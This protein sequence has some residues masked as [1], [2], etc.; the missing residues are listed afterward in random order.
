MTEEL[1]SEEERVVEALTEHDS[2]RY[3]GIEAELFEEQN[4]DAKK[5]NDVKDMLE[6]LEQRGV[7]EKH[8]DGRYTR[9]RPAKPGAPRPREYSFSD[10]MD[11][12]AGLRDALDPETEQYFQKLIEQEVIAEYDLDTDDYM[13]AFSETV[14][15]IE[16]ETGSSEF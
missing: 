3:I 12:F 2:L 15:I 8:R 11:H 16:E 6:D 5:A 7:I 14:D 1:T 13:V 4:F 10:V 9:Y